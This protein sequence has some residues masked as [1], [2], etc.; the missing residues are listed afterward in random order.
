MIMF[1]KAMALVLVL[2]MAVGLAAC[3]SPSNPSSSSASSE[4]SASSTPESSE[5]SSSESSTASDDL[6]TPYGKYPEVIE[7]H[8]AKR[9]SSAPNFAEG[10]S[11]GDNAMT[12]YVLDKLNVKT[13]IDWE[14]EGPEFPNKLSLMIASDSLPDMF[15]LT[16]NDYL[17]YRQLVDNEMLADLS[18]GYEKCAGDYMKD[19]FASFNEENLAPFREGDALYAIAGGR[20]GYEHN[21]L[22]LRQDWMEKVGITEMP[23]T[24][25]DIKNILV[26]FKE[27]PPV[28]GYTGMILNATKIAGGYGN[29]YSADP[30]FEVF[31]ATPATWIKGSDGKI[32][33][34]SVMPEMKEGL[35]VLAEWYAEGL[36]DQQFATRTATGATDALFTGSQAGVAFAPWWYCYTIGDLPHN[37]PDAVPAVVNAPLDANGKF[38]VVWPGPSGD[39]LMVNKKFEHPEAVVKVLNCEYDMW[40]E[41]DPEG[42]ALIKPNRDANVDWGYMFPTSG[43]NLEYADIIPN[44]GLLAK[45][46]I[47][48]DKL[49]GADSA[50]EMDKTMAKDAK[51]YADTKSLD[52]MGWIHYYGRYIASNLVTQPEVNVIKPAFSF[53]TE[54]MAD[55]KAN[56]DTLEQTTFLKIV[57]GEQP[58]DSF[59]QFV[60][61]WYA[62]GGQQMTDEVNA[63]AK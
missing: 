6:M 55:L 23:K 7:M 60:T 58:V 4:S 8:T 1:K 14:V 19:V 45:N 38:N 37:N 3:G 33:W 51:N 36:I 16:A 27:N 57:T 56:L 61:D 28:E 53:T 17:I 41:I 34:G 59:D 5:E 18:E 44:V 42:A 43:V 54:S 13:V 39:F 31:G 20:Y 48:N 29:S 15:T 26:A 11:V 9:I 47:E 63:M 35:K 49:E 62:Q 10:D 22:W 12:R 21:E 52:G 30:I 50:T 24:L 40:R 32:V 25:D 2:A 46:Y